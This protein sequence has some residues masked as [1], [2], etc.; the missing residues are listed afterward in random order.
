MQNNFL[1]LP[2]GS[3]FFHL[4]KVLATT[5]SEPGLALPGHA[6]IVGNEIADAPVKEAATEPEC[7]LSRA[8]YR[9]LRRPSR[10]LNSRN[11]NL[12]GITQCMVECTITIC[13]FQKWT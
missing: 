13:L 10:K 2:S 9:R 11:G 4:A 3:N 1:I 5:N 8:I 7:R 6:S 12:D